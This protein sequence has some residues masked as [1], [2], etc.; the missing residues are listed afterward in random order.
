MLSLLTI[1]VGFT[2]CRFF[3]F[4]FFYKML[5]KGGTYGNIFTYFISNHLS[6]YCCRAGKRIYLLS[7]SNSVSM[8]YL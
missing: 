3:C 7:T 6:M 5:K 1:A 8:D 4:L 2:S